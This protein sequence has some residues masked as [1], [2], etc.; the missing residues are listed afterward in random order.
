MHHHIATTD[1]GLQAGL[2]GNFPAIDHEVFQ[3]TL[4]VVY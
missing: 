4:Q 3:L 2:P 1:C